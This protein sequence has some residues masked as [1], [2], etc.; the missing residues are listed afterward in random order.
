YAKLSMNKEL[1]DRIIFEITE[2]NTIK[3][4][5]TVNHFIQV[6]K[7]DG[8]KVCLDD[9]GVGSAS[10]QYLH[11]LHVDYVKVDGSYTRKILTSDRDAIMVKNLTQM[12]KDLKTVVIAEMVE[13]REQ[14][15]LLQSLGIEFGQGYLFGRPSGK[16]EYTPAP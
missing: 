2:S 6:L 8:F 4:F 9:F 12:C 11:K 1:A 10:F 3:D 5:D 15:T 16:P 14:A 7:G 13:S